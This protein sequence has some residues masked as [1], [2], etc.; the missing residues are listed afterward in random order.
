MTIS[1]HWLKQY[2]PFALS[3][4][5]LAEV[6]THC[7]LEVESFSPFQSV[8]GGLKGVVVGEVLECVPHPD[9]DK[10]KVTR[11]NIGEA[12]PLQIVCGA[13]NVA[14][15]QKVAVATI[16][17]TL[18][19]IVGE[20][21]QIKKAKIRGIESRGMICAEDELG[22]GSD[23][24]GIIILNPLLTPGT[25]CAEVFGVTED[26]VFEIGLTPNRTDAFS[27]IGVARDL[28]AALEIGYKTA[29]SYH[30]PETGKYNVTVGIEK[31]NIRVEATEACKRYAG[32][33]LENITIGPSPDW[34][35]HRLRAIGVKCIN[36]VVDIT[37]FVLHE[38][39]Q[40]LHAFDLDRLTGNQLIVRMA[41]EGEKLVTLD[42]QERTLHPADLVIGDI[43][44]P[45]CIAGVL[46]GAESGVQATTRRIFLESA[47]FNP[48][49]IRQTGQRLGVKT[50]ASAH[51]EKG[52]DPDQV[53]WALQRAADLMIQHC[54]ASVAGDIID[55]YPEPIQKK[56]IS[57]SIEGICGIAGTSIPAE[58]IYRSLEKL[59]III[60]SETNHELLLEIP[61]FKV[62]VTRE[63][64]IAEDVLRLYGYNSIPIPTRL[65]SSISLQGG[66][67]PQQE[68]NHISQ[69]LAS[70]GFREIWTNSIAPSTWDISET[71]QAERIMLL[72]SQTSTLDSLRTS[73]VYS[74]LEVILHNIN[75]KQEEL[76]FFEMGKT[77]HREQN[78]F[79]QKQLLTLYL[80][81]LRNTPN[82]ITP[83]TETN[84]FHLKNTVEQILD[85]YPTES[86]SSKE[87]E[88]HPHWD[89]GIS[90][91]S[92]NRWLAHY[93]KL[94]QNLLRTVDIKKTV[95]Y[96]ELNWDELLEI[97]KR[98]AIQFRELP[99][100]PSV[101]RD[102]SMILDKHTSFLNLEEIARREGRKLL[103]SVRLI[104]VYTGDKIAEG[105][106]S[107]TLRFTFRDQEKTLTDTEIEGVMNRLIKRLQLELNAQIRST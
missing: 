101:E 91:Y 46:G 47:W 41:R 102:L 68:E 37:N 51:F 93:G 92:G 52:C 98:S 18:H 50:D 54:G 45:V 103:E 88:N 63:A 85:R 6:L 58:I 104:D 27:H 4:E 69:Y 67:N 12:E 9:A 60:L 95:W 11:V 77:Y 61:H 39:G 20:P 35:Q 55:W 66:M 14:S 64:D 29:I 53:I 32:I 62:D 86:R 96:A 28:A 16:G 59:G 19:P 72:N 100:F 78:Q 74:G 25:P 43:H 75:R 31:L 33:V 23:H 81:G 97:R 89:W 21:I 15:G 106:K 94:S 7:G 71:A 80:C 105:K 76:A 48:Q 1:Y 82:W 34:I 84:F 79:I 38:C 87:I 42:Q 17:C 49:H 3:P 36:N 10:L 70:V 30:V 56:Q 22:L 83:S 8:T 40:P 5:D 24:N 107:Y 57:I 99:R 44:H 13:A 26:F 73:M 90:V 65:R 2:I